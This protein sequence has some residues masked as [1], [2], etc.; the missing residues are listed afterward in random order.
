ME[1]PYCCSKGGNTYYSLTYLPAM[2]HQ[3][4]VGHQQKVKCQPL[5]SLRCG[6]FNFSQCPYYWFVYQFVT[7]MP[8]WYPSGIA[9]EKE[10]GALI[11]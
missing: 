4:Q 10:N 9:V 11:F 6:C 3:L 2:G 1:R 5:H 7:V 8:G